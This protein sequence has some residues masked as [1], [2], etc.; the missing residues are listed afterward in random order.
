M[1][2]HSNTPY[3]LVF[4][5]SIYDIFGFSYANYRFYDS[6]PGKVKVSCGGVCRNIAENMSRVGVNT[7]FISII[8]DDQKGNDILRQAEKVGLDMSDSLIVEGGSTPTYLAIL[9]ENGEMVSAVVD[10]KLANEFSEEELD[11][12][13]AVIEGA[14]YMFVGADNAPFLEYMLKKY[15][16]KTKFV[17]DPVSAA[18][19]NRIKHLLPYFH[20]VK[21]NR[22]EAGILCGF[23]I[24]THEDMRRAGAYIRSLGV[25]KVFIS[26]DVEG[27]YYNDGQEE[28]LIRATCTE[29]RN[30]TGAGDA[31]VAGMGCAYMTNKSVKDTV[32]FAIAMSNITISHEETIHPEMTLERV[33]AYLEDA[34][35]EIIEFK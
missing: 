6:N 11:K 22:H 17:L 7:K 14:E 21:P 1:M 25:E 24:K 4:G 26:L 5:I 23:E 29:V 31:F 19:A 3:A 35:W 16:D 2:K 10:T 28:G 8:G 20:T 9:D 30:V 13:A 33:E 34:E 32:K 18:K 15:H 27:V 12:R